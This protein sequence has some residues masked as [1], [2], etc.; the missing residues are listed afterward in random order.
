[1]QRLGGLRI[2]VESTRPVPFGENNITTFL[3]N[4]SFDVA[5][6]C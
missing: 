3:T 1:M 4:M 6:I 2:F 5:A